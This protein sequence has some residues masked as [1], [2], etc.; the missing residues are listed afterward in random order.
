MKI[1]H[2]AVAITLLFAGLV[3]LNFLAY[4]VPIRFDFTADRIFTLSPGTKALLGKIEEPLTI[5]FYFSR[6]SADLPINVKDYADRVEVTLRQYVRASHGKIT[7]HLIDPEADTPA[8]EQATRNGIQAQRVQVGAQPFYFG[9]VATE[10]DKTKAIA[11]LTPEREQFLEYDL[12][13][14]IYNVQQVN[15]KKL[16]LITSLPLQGAGGNPMLGQP[17]SEP[18]Y[19]VS[20][21]QD[22]FD[23]VP[24]EASATE[25]PANLDV[26]AV[27]HPENLTPKLQFAIDQF[28][29][30]GKPV[31]I[32]VDPASQYFKA[33]AGQMAMFGGPQPNVASSLP[34]L[35]SGWGI[36]F[37]PQRIVGDTAS[38]T[39]VQLRDGSLARYPVWLSLT[40]A[41]FNHEALPTAQLK[42]LLF[43]EPGSLALAPGSTLTF[44]P[45]VRTSA[46]AGD[47]EAAAI[48]F[49]QPDEVA[50]QLT[51]S[52]EKTIAA[53]ISGKFSTAFPDGSPK[54]EKADA[55]SAAGGPAGFLKQSTTRST[56]I[57][58]ADTDW[59]LDDYS[60]RKLN[61]LGTS[62]AEPLNDN[63]SFAANA[64]D[65]LAGSE[66]LLSIRGKG[67]SLRPFK[68]V[69]AMENKA[70]EK[71]QEELNALESQLSTVQSKLTEL[72]GKQTEGNRLVASPEVAKAIQDFQTQESRLRARRR[73]IR[74]ALT[75]GINALKYWLLALN[76]LATPLLACAIGFAYYRHRRK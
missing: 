70:N 50:K 62:A 41:D 38:A 20:M 27:V 52:G 45:L 46:Q 51:P 4:N 10:A 29:L 22:T 30:A 15:K 44:T 69:Q 68:V 37:N 25:L 7:L 17:G 58:V 75:Q 32:A 11:S 65:Y 47:L 6:D 60:V 18:Q 43:I 67:V 53:L 35:F 61:L 39:Q 34:T 24:L 71:Y 57:V 40:D 12:S 16:G 54:D 74:L 13:E 33:Q 23:I 59:M 26:L 14:L 1:R 64:L 48:Q 36:Q 2:K 49:A 73:E 42:S 76:I 9:L 63:L 66:D 28:L 3:L 72:Q 8:E 55:K 5:D 21:W 19:V 31:F 56:L